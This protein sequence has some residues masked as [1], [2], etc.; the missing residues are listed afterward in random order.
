MWYSVRK[1]PSTYKACPRPDT[2][3]AYHELARA[4]IRGK[5]SQVLTRRGS[6]GN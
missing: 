2:S 5:L 1:A 3:G 6:S 4:S